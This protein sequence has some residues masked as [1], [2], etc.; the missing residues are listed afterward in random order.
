MKEHLVACA[1]RGTKDKKWLDIP[2][3]TYA[4]DSEGAELSSGAY[5]DIPD[6]ESFSYDEKTKRINK[7]K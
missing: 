2:T 1:A 4:T 5:L 7:T 3:G 6:W